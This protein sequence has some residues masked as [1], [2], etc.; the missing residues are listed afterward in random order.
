MKAIFITF[1]Q[2]HFEKIMSIL[3]HNNCRGFSYWE[4]LQGRG[5]SEGEPH[6]GSHA[7]PGMN[8]AI[9]TMVDDSKV[10]SLLELLHNL[11]AETPALG[12]RAFVW[13][14]ENAI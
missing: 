4:N 14:I 11:D 8:S 9:I 7:W 12:L 3:N 2:A 13:N 1:D 5:S 6:Y 10:N